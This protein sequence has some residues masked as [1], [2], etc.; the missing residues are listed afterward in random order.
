[1]SQE[2]L[3]AETLI[4]APMNVV[5]EAWT[6][7]EH[8]MQWNAAS[9]DWH[10]PKAVNPL[11]VGLKFSSR[12]EAK[13]GSA[14]FD[15]EG[16]YTEIIPKQVLAYTM[17]DGRTVRVEFAEEGGGVR[18]VEWFDPEHENTVELQQQGWQS[19][20]NNFKQYAESLAQK[21]L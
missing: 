7:P 11:E 1:M 5:W 17:D 18:V 2:Q 3:K 20:L 4:A 13:D 15:F 6:A 14:G 21:S 16:T 9:P 8:I 12:M 10:C 19:I